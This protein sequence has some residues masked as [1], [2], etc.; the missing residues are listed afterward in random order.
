MKVGILGFGSMGRSHARVIQRIRGFEL[1]GFYDPGY[2]AED[3]SKILRK[4][5]VKDL[6]SENPD[7]LVIASPTQTHFSAIIQLI[8]SKIPLLVE[9]PIC[10]KD[11]ESTQLKELSTR[12]EFPVAV[13]HVE[14]FNPA[15][16]AAREIVQSGVIGSLVSIDTFRKGPNPNRELGVGVLLDL[17]SHDVDTTM[18]LTGQKYRDK[19]S[20][21][22]SASGANFE[23]FAVMQGVMKE[24]TIVRHQVDWLSPFKVRQSRIMGT[25]GVLTV[26]TVQNTLELVR[27]YK[28][29]PKVEIIGPSPGS[30]EPLELEHLHFKRLI[31][32]E[33]SHIATLEEALQVVQILLN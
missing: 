11:F 30:L 25:K 32:G 4:S 17:M 33:A 20:R 18:W 1:V 2:E 16:I 29:G 8:E 7:Y 31:M 6:V 21:T 22:Y 10:C 13:G 26:D 3:D 28:S 24:G 19:S 12:L 15:M 5:S 27:E 14:R 9:K 23:S